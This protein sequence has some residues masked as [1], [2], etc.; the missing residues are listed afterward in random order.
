MKTSQK[1]VDHDFLLHAKARYLF[2]NKCA[3]SDKAR[4]ATTFL[5][6]TIYLI[7]NAHDMRRRRYG[8]L[9]NLCRYLFP[10]I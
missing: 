5:H 1:E 7:I 10:H 3:Y 8:K 4:D 9:R 6:L 2:N